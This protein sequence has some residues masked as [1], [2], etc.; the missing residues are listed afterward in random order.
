MGEIL[1]HEFITADGVIDGPTWSEDYEFDDAMNDA[2]T[3]IT[4]RCAAILLGRTSWQLFEEGWSERTDADDPQSSFLNDTPK[5]VVSGTIDTPTWRNSTILPTYDPDAIR[6]LKKEVDGD[7]FTGASGTLVR[8]L[9][10]DDLVDELNLFVYPLTRGHGP[11]LF[12]ADAPPMT[13]R[14]AS[15]RAFDHGVLHLTYRPLR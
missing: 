2:V 13:M 8:A 10:A 12:P 4:G 6:Q 7:I 1:V 14:L 5:Y 15:H 3:G 9:L 11:R